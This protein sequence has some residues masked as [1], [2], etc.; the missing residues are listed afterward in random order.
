MSFLGNNSFYDEN[1]M[2]SLPPGMQMVFNSGADNN[3]NLVPITTQNYMTRYKELENIL[4]DEK[5]A[6]EEIKQFYKALKSDHTRHVSNQQEELI[7]FFQMK[8]KSNFFATKVE[9]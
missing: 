3:E 7:H 4:A 9:K 1:M 2:L 5:K 8:S 6:N